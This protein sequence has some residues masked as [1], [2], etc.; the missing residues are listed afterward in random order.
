MHEKVVK[1]KTPYIGNGI[2]FALL[3]FLVCTALAYRKFHTGIFNKSSTQRE[4]SIDESHDRSPFITV[5]SHK[6]L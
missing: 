6:N 4:R 5:C 1:L 2:P 3:A